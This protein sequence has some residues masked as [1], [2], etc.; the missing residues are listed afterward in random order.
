MASF[1]RTIQQEEKLEYIEE[2]LSRSDH[3]IPLKFYPR[4][5]HPGDFIYLAYRGKIVGRALVER[6]EPVA[7]EVLIGSERRSYQAECLVRYKGG[8][9]RSPRDIPFEGCQGI[10]YLD[11]VGLESLDSEQW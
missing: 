8:W 4:R 5:V 11:R 6:I 2:I 3:Y 9:Q 10:R 1:V 7:D